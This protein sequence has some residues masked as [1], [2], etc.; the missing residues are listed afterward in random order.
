MKIFKF[1]GVSVKSADA[2]KNLVTILKREGFDN[3][4]VVISAMGKMTN[5][6]EKVVDDYVKNNETLSNS[7][8]VT[9]NYH[10][11]ICEDL[12]PKGHVVF[13]EIELIFGKLS[14]FMAMNRSKNFDFIYDQ[15]VS[16]GELLS[17]KIVSF[18]LEDQ[19]ITNTW[20]DVRT[21]IY[22]DT[23]FRAATV[24]W[25]QT[26]I[27]IQNNIT[28]KLSIT[29]GFI[30]GGGT[31]QTT[32]L[33]REGSDYTAA[34]FAY[35]LNASSVTIWKDVAGVLNA[36]P[37]YFNNT[38]LLKQI[39]YKEATEMAFYGASVIHPKTLKPL[40]NK[41]IP[42]FVRSFNNLKSVGT[43]VQKGISIV[44]KTPCFIQKK[45][46][47]LVS[48][49]AKDFS[50]MVESNL[51]HV[52]QLLNDFKL[53]V[54]LIQ[55]SAL[56][57]SVCVEDNYDQFQEFIKIVQQNYTVYYNS[58]TTLYTIRYATKKAVK[59]IEEKGEVLLKQATK[60]TVQI[61]LKTP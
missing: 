20:I 1:G 9:R 48:I 61:V 10:H 31:N 59:M 29:Q 37:R 36:D 6:F 11:K 7:I 18:H 40:E 27:N 38:V 19:Q 28:S 25:K 26:K 30:A 4:L 5:A 32:T 58:D 13:M 42:L 3:T 39:S 41:Q 22:T 8:D 43:A 24:N 55:N 16:C 56:S 17:T 2:I 34:I 44:P 47:Y 49:S 54:N 46:Q 35:C 12:F 52:F 15:I 60:Q 51:S 14:G 45:S 53:K 23:N 21:C 57:F 33:G 50:F